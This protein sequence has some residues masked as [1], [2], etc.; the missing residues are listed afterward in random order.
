M[1][2]NDARFADVAKWKVRL[3]MA[4]RGTTLS[5]LFFLLLEPVISTLK[6][7]VEKPLLILVKDESASI[8]FNHDSLQLQTL[9]LKF[10]ELA[11]E[12]EKDFEV[13]RFGFGNQLTDQPGNTFTAP[14]TDMSAM[15]TGVE[16]R[17]INRNVGALI[18]VSDG[19]Y[20]KG[21]N[22]LYSKQ[23]FDFPLYSVA[24]GD[25][26]QHYDA[27]LKDIKSNRIAH[28]GNQF[29]LRANVQAFGAAQK[30]LVVEVSQNGR[31]I[32]SRKVKVNSASFSTSIDF[33]LTAND[34]G[35]Q[36]YT[37]KLIPLEGEKNKVNNVREVFIEVLEGKQS[38]LLLSNAPH[39]DLGALYST[40]ATF[41]NYQLNNVP[42]DR[43][44]GNVAPY[45]LIVLHQLPATNQHFN[46]IQKV[47]DSKA[48]CLFILGNQTSLSAFNKLN[49]GLQIKGV[50]KGRINEAQALFQSNFPLFTL[51]GETATA[52]ENFPPL[53]T[54]LGEY[55]YDETF[56]V[57]FKQKIGRVK[58]EY[59][60][61]AFI[62]KENKKIG[63]ISGTGI[64]RWKLVDYQKN[65][66]HN[67]SSEFIE[68]AVQYL[69][70]KEDKSRFRIHSEH[71]FYENEAIVFDAE[72]YNEA[73]ELTNQPEVELRITDQSGKVYPFV[74]NRSDKAYVLN[75]GTLPAGE[76][77]YTA[78]VRLGS[79]TF[80]KNGT[81]AVMP[82]VIE[83][84]N[85]IADYELLDK[86]SK[87]YGGSMVT[88]EN[89][90]EL[91]SQI[92]N[93][94]DIRPVE[95]VNE[96]PVDLIHLKWLFFLLLLLISS[97]WY[98]RKRNGA[99]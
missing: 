11:S 99:Y 87:K 81:L 36:H 80:T 79:E 2:R 60:L 4:L 27:I 15:L 49:T 40:L 58:S 1:Y 74:F 55:E 16:E 78:S 51:N 39:P 62:K 20:N 25:T 59:P 97:E 82:V 53:E 38:I 45:D 70:I 50:S 10:E 46:T 91:I 28:L 83:S 67:K 34:V 86:L 3:M 13:R 52:L 72:L 35:I 47:M 92:Q 12:L 6:R 77:K 76:Y 56:E 65:E 93:N 18:V 5:L 57:L 95:H 48:S 8:A 69:A 96:E 85:T 71:Q 32:A 84:L 43:F 64:W 37:V 24:I 88:L 21:A 33:L 41:D 7:R 9:N 94:Q 61:V 73:Y 54:P 31:E 98:L 90:N 75:A 30:E 23:R 63:F 22:P 26:A 66:S 29:P 17:F 19:R 42:I 68:K 89:T 44:D 14:Y